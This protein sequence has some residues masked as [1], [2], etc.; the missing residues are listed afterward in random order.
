VSIYT[1]VLD[2]LS[3][4]YLETNERTKK[5]AMLADVT[6]QG[7]Q[8]EAGKGRRIARLNEEEID[9]LIEKMKRPRPVLPVVL[10]VGFLG[11]DPKERE[12][13]LALRTYMVGEM[14][15]LWDYNKRLLDQYN[16]LGYAEVLVDDQNMWELY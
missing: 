8:V 2:S 12:E 14:Q 1:D 16:T 5:E 11:K 9:K 3:H 15:L 10:P 7:R 13:Y 6:V 4:E